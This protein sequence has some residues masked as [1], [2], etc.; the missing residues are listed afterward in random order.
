[1]KRHAAFKNVDILAMQHAIGGVWA[2]NI[3]ADGV[4]GAAAFGFG[5][6]VG[7]AGEEDVGGA[8]E[9]LVVGSRLESRWICFAD[10]ALPDAAVAHLGEGQAVAA[11]AVGDVAV[12]TG[13]VFEV[14]GR[15][16]DLVSGRSE[17]QGGN[18]YP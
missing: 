6:V 13:D 16:L 7:E 10:E 12:R 15:V 8:F 3:V 2:L 1:M 5:H 4:D 11:V 18:A 9:G 14:C 17:R